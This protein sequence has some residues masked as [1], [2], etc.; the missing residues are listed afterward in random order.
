MQKR[1]KADKTVERI[2]DGKVVP[3]S[4][5]ARDDPNDPFSKRDMLF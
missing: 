4:K 5:H 1:Y 2:I 3:Y